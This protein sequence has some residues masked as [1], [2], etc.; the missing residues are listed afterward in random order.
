MKAICA[1]AWCLWRNF[2][3]AQQPATELCVKIDFKLNKKQYINVLIN[4]ILFINGRKIHRELI[5]EFLKSLYFI[6]Y[7]RPFPDKSINKTIMLGQ[8]LRALREAKGLL[9]RQVAAALDVDTAY[10]SKM[11]KNEKPVSKNYLSSLSRLYGVPEKELLTL[12]LA[13]K[14]YYVVKDEA[15]AFKAIEIAVDELKT[16][17]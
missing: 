12:W 17:K 8:K 14:V 5:I 10:V 13:N 4:R 15:D 16:K 7:I 9:Q 1:A 6:L 11:E 3:S 2:L